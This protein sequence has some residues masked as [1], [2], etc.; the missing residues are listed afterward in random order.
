MHYSDLN[1]FDIFFV[2]L[3]VWLIGIVYYA[4]GLNIK[5]KIDKADGDGPG[6]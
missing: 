4:L 1:A 6:P 2:A 3:M 5:G